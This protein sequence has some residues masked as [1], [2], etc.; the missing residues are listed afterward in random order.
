M[1]YIACAAVFAAGASF[2]S[3]GSITTM[4]T[5]GNGGSSLW[6]NYFDA[7][8]T[9]GI[10][11]TGFD[12]NASD[13]G[14]TFTLDVYARSG[15][16][17]GFETNGGA[18]W[19][20]VGSGTAVAGGANVPTFVDVSDFALGSGITGLALRYS[21]SGMQYTNGNGTNQFFSNADVSLTLGSSAAT[22]GGAFA[23][24]SSLFSPRIWNGTMYYNTVPEPATLAVLGIGALAALRR[25]RRK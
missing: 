14:S 16:Y 3:A 25:R 22:T 19:T 24:G 4:F 8:V 6:T 15:T 9:S 21:G 13:T 10:T 12:V 17:S 1:K 7:N 23:S 18:G 20:L 2:A 11:V 5:G